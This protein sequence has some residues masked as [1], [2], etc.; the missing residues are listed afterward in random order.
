MI[1]VAGPREDAYLARVAGDRNATGG[2][3]SAAARELR[4][5]R[6]AIFRLERS[7]KL[8]TTAATQEAAADRRES[9]PRSASEPRPSR[10]HGA[11]GSK[12][13][14][15]PGGRRIAKRRQGPKEIGNAGATRY[16]LT[17]TT[18][19]GTP[20]LDQEMSDEHQA[21]IAALKQDRSFVS[22]KEWRAKVDIKQGAPVIGKDPVVRE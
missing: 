18:S 3:L 12:R 17:K 14:E 9:E 15:Q 11:P 1:S 7:R 2:A 21:L 5:K 6:A 4:S 8:G 22:V 16:F 19:S 20:E 10:E 13:D